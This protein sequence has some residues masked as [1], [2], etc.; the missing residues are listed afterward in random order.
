[1]I[2][3]RAGSYG[4]SV[5]DR[6]L[7]RKR[8]VGTFATLKEAREAERQASAS[9]AARGNQWCAD[10]VDTWLRDYPRTAPAT[11][12][13]Y[14]YALQTFKRDFAGVRLRDLDKPTARAWALHAPTSNVRVA[15]AMLTDAISRRSP[16]AS[17]TSWRTARWSVTAHSGRRSAR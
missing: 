9:P 13:T 11:V 14:R 5:Y 3:K 10:F 8:W 4:V 1:M 6:A 17:C 16:R 15:R 12:R 7:K 2:V